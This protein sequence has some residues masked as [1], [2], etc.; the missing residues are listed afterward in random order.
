MDLW[1]HTVWQEP[2]NAFSFLSPAIQYG[3]NGAVMTLEALGRRWGWEKT[4]VW[5]FFQKH[6][7]AFALC[8]LPGRC[9]CLIFNRLYPAGAA[10]TI[11]SQEAIDALSAID[12]SAELC[13]GIKDTLNDPQALEND[14]L[15][16]W[17]LSS[18]VKAG[19]TVK[20]PASPVTFNGENNVKDFTRAPHLGEHTLEVLRSVG[21]TEEKV[22]AMAENKVTVIE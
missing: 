4:K 7:D 1:C 19:Q 2:D 20:L 8:R 3:R 14:Y 5:R 12:I 9:G 18:G 6:G 10:F 16:D 22:R 13:R 15:F 17:T 11:P 21:Y